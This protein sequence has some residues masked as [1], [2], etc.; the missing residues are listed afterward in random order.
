MNDVDR[1]RAGAARAHRAV[2][3]TLQGLTDEQVTEPSFLPGWTVGHVATHIARN[4]EGHLRMLHAA[5]RGEVATMYPGG[6]E[7]RTGDIEAGAHRSASELLTDVTTGATQ[8]EETWAAMPE[9]AWAGHG[10][11]FLGDTTMA[12]LVFIRWRE[13]TVHHADLGLGYSWNDWDS[14]YVRLELARLTMLWASRRPMG[15]TGLPL[16]AMSVSDHHRVAWLLGR[17]EID[18]LPAAGIMV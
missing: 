2:V 1:D 17:T 15:L 3:A 4:A 16:E 10:I 18:G 9:A 11:T 5:M 8:M 14:D 13:A 12:D 7:Q 6:P